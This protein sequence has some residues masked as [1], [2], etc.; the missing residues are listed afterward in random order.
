MLDAK[1]MRSR[2]RGEAGWLLMARK[3]G[4]VKEIE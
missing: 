2:S 4:W 1:F 3:Y